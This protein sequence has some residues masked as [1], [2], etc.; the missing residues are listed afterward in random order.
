MIETTQFCLWKERV[1]R[2]VLKYKIG[3]QSDRKS[4]KRGGH[5]YGTSLPCIS[6]GVTPLGMPPPQ[7]PPE[8]NITILIDTMQIEE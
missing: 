2:I 7:P 3:T 1:N 5:H 8:F 6:M 4:Q